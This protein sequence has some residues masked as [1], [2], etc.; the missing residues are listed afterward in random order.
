MTE[1]QLVQDYYD[2]LKD[3]M[4]SFDEDRLRRILAPD[5]VFEGP[6]AGR[7]VGARHSSRASPGSPR[8][9]AA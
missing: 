3:G 9:C 6:I 7:H 8:R 4:A 1:E 2:T 5:L